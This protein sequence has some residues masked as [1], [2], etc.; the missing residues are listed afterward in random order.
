MPKKT[1]FKL[2]EQRRRMIIEAFLLE[3][4]KY[5]YDTA[6]VSQTLVKMD[7]SKGSFYQYFESK[8]E[9][10]TYLQQHCGKVKAEYIGNIARCDYPD[11]WQYFKALYVKGVNIYLDHPLESNF[12]NALM[13]H[14][15]SPTVKPLYDIWYGQI[16]EQ[17]KEWVEHEVEQGLFRDD[18]SVD[19]MAFMLY[20]MN[21][22]LIELMGFKI[23]Q[24]SNPLLDSPPATIESVDR[25]L[26]LE[27]VDE[28]ILLLSNACNNL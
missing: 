26:L 5:P 9:L 1:F 11:F 27:A 20:K 24:K 10:F 4:T 28:I 6:S 8:L 22:A 21:T 7:I 2:A 3:F 12:L 23:K 14:A 13:K 19:S 16:M 18:V 25:D 17:M 15:S